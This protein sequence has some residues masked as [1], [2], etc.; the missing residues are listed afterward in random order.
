[1]GTPIS[2]TSELVNWA[3]KSPTV[4]VNTESGG[5]ITFS[6][7]LSPYYTK[8]DLQ[9]A[10]SA[11][12]DWSNIQNVVLPIA[13]EAEVGG[14]IVGTGL[15]IDS[16]G[17]LN[18]TGGYMDSSGA[19]PA[20]WGDIS[21]NIALQT[22]LQSALGLKLDSADYTA[23]DV[24]AKLI[25]VDGV[26]SGLDADLLDG[27]HG[28][29]YATKVHNLIDTTNHPVTGLTTGHF[30]K[31]L[32]ATTYGF[33]AHGL[34]YTD[35]N[36]TGITGTPV[37][38]QIAVWTSANTLEGTTGLTYDGAT[39]S[40][41]VR[42]L[43]VNTIRAFE[44]TG[45]NFGDPVAFYGSSSAVGG[46]TGLIISPGNEP[47]SIST[48]STFLDKNGFFIAKESRDYSYRPDFF[49]FAGAS[50]DHF[51]RGSLTDAD[52][53]TYTTVIIGTQ[54]WMV[55]NFKSTKYSD[56]SNI[57][58]ATLFSTWSANRS[59][60]Y[61]WYNN[62]ITNKTAYGALYNRYAVDSPYPKTLAPAGWRVPYP[63]D[64]QVLEDYLGG[65]SIAGKH[66]KI[67]GFGGN[68]ADNS[69]GFTGV[70]GGE[71]SSTNGSFDQLGSYSWY[72]TRY[73]MPRYLKDAS[74]SLGI[75]TPTPD[76][77]RSVRLMRDIGVVGE[78]GTPIANQI[79]V[80]N[81]DFV[82]QGIQGFT[83]DG[84]RFIAP[85]LSIPHGSAPNSPVNGDIWTTT[86]GLY[87]RING[88]TIGPYGTGTGNAITPVDNI[89]D[90]D[91]GNSWYAPYAVQGAGH[92]DSGTV[93]PSHSNR[94]NYDGDFHATRVYST[95]E[96][97]A[98]TSATYSHMG[99]GMFEIVLN[100]AL[101]T[102]FQP[103]ISDSTSPVIAYMYDTGSTFTHSG[104]KLFSVKNY[105]SEKFYIDKD[106]GCGINSLTINSSLVTAT[107][108][109]INILHELDLNVIYI[110][111]IALLIEQVDAALT[112][113]TPSAANLN[114]ALGMTASVAGKN[115]TKIIKDTSGSAL[116]YLVASD[117]V[118][119]FYSKL[120]KAI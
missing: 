42:Y 119:W 110:G 10:G 72:W 24:L 92:F 27:Q 55:E 86:A 28:S 59:G 64:F 96:C 31:A 77:G 3:S 40:L 53:N 105:G 67:V 18:V 11:L 100:T 84:T 87:A 30:L 113:D 97:L 112:D 93:D 17:V 73:G 60:A 2:K 99:S 80:W 70:A 95:T 23:S 75:D 7:D 12:V 74:D 9:T 91:A 8:I 89:L 108:E 13:S 68:V 52:G 111:D 46:V 85:L 4:N 114:S 88:A 36:A 116:I 120:S 51:R 5:F 50:H 35:V 94:L 54:E 71:R 82:I 44:Y 57:T 56:G 43:K 38:N 16:N 90:W 58:N 101:R 62:D 39:F 104:S 20:T 19:G 26:A 66:M 1:M 47:Y 29:Y 25:T 33:A 103:D 65:K 49:A 76:A 107:A 22:D 117:G 21:G 61:C 118:D 115:Y 102:S 37:D 41:S 32:S 63:E 45:I 15:T 14:I 78:I 81:N 79:A 6:V 109:E 83:F 106:G 98:G 69:S 48:G 34:T